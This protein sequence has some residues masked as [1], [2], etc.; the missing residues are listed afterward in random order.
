MLSDYLVL[1]ETEILNS[2]RLAAYIDAL[3][4]PL[5]TFS[6]CGCP[7]LTATVLGDEE[8]TTP[9]EDEAEWYDPDVPESGSFLGLLVLSIE[10]LEDNPVTRQVTRSVTGGAALGPARVLPRT[11][12]VTA[13]LIGTTCCGVTYGLRWL[14]QALAGCTGGDCGG[15]CAELVDCCPSEDEAQDPAAFMDRHRRTLRRVALT[16]GPT[17]LSRT[18]D[19]C[20]GTGE[21]QIGADLVT[22]E[23]V[24]TA[25]SPYLW[26]DPVP[27]LS[28]PVPTDDADECVTWCLHSDVDTVCV[29]Q[30]GRCSTGAAAVTVVADGTCTLAVPVEEPDITPCSSCRLTD[31]EAEG[32]ACAD[33]SCATPLPPVPPAPSTC[34]CNA[35]AVNTEY[36]DLDLTSWPRWFGAAPM[37][38]V[39]AGAADL[40]R[41]TITIY[42]RTPD[43]AA[44]TC[45]QIAL[46]YRCSPHS[47]FEIAF[48]PEAGALTL[49]GQT[50]RGTVRCADGTCETSSSVYGADGGP[51]EFPLLDC[52]KYCVAISS[53][54]S[55]PPADDAVIHF[56][57]SGREY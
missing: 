57:L 8:Y 39:E 11:I 3:G 38:T 44:L 56:A 31:C 35:L 34:F 30:S 18:G 45:E 24:L 2:A 9:E 23:F 49:D 40:R 25:A 28:V 15:D 43:D 7:A 6:G 1:G 21:C 52:D 26:R 10:G 50:G 17:V 16:S 41:V 32:A 47:T 14:S 54:T 53:D 55:K 22:I 12:T 42:Q 48:V 46:K 19:G 13:V 51:M 36:Y 33:S 37:V 20:S 29:E 27:L 4:S 5:T